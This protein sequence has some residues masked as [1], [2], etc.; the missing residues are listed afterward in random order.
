MSLS[1]VTVE[2]EIAAPPAEIFALVADAAKHALID[3]SGT[4]SGTRQESV[5][6]TLGTRFS[7]GMKRGARYRTTNTVVEHEPDRRIAWKTTN[8]FGLAGGRVWRYE[9]EPTATG[10]LVRETWDPTA[11]TLRFGFGPAKM[12]KVAKAG[13]HRTLERIA[14][15]LEP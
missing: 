15:L 4:V 10:T 14:E 1:P 5:P 7:M 3:G 11:D 13:M 2:R 9:L 6:L 12:D 8:L